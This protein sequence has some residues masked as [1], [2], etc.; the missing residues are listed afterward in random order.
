MCVQKHKLQRFGIK[1]LQVA[2]LCKREIVAFCHFFFNKPSQQEAWVLA[3][4]FFSSLLQGDNTF[5]E[6]E[7]F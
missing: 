1:N 6:V 7:T 4:L 3:V 2:V 5:Q